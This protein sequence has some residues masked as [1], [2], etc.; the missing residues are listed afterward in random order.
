M[1]HKILENEFKQDYY[2]KLDDFI[3]QERITK[4][5]Y[6]KEEDVFRAFELTKLSNLKVVILGQD[7]YF[8]KD[9]ADGLAFSTRLD[10]TPKSLL[11]IKKELENDLD[12]KISK[13]N[14]LSNW[15]KEG[16]LLLNTILTVE[17]NNDLT[18]QNKG[19]EIF[20]LN[21]FK[22]IASL[23][24]PMVFILWGNKAREYKKYI[25]NKNHLIIESSHPSPLS[26]YHSFWNSKPFSKT[27]NYLIKNEIK[28]IDFTL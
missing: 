4:T 26:A 6:P 20:T 8:V 24:R 18:H 13:N 17:A 1:W 16:V 3:K 19:W 28:P 2:K 9:M 14:D 25:T 5:I 27:N 7:P 21:I 11:N 12:I 23:N 15:A 10:K 22:Y